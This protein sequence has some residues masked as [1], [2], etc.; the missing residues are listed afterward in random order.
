MKLIQKLV[1][2]KTGYVILVISVLLV[3]SMTYLP[4]PRAFACT[5][6]DVNSAG[7]CTNPCDNN[8]PG[9]NQ[10]VACAA[11]TQP[12]SGSTNCA[13]GQT[14]AACIIGGYVNPVIGV[15]SAL[16]GVVVVISIIA[17]G[18]QYS[19]SAGDPQKA[20]KAKSRITNALI[21]LVAFGFLFSFL[22]FLLPGGFL[23]S[24]S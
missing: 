18:I 12:A 6:T 7:A 2:L 14:G 15:L 24:G 10:S 17:G 8:D 1:Q 13:K 16:V 23:N 3:L 11:P 22:E 4:L 20:A 19:T 9:V 21:A 5:Q